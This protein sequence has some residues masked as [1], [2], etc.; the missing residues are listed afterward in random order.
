M[1]NNQK[2]TMRLVDRKKDA[3]YVY[4]KNAIFDKNTRN[5]KQNKTLGDPVN[6]A[7]SF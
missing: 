1:N 5:N 2:K 7:P 6:I 4:D 3:I